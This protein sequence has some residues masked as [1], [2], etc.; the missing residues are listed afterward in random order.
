LSLA[1]LPTF[2]LP[3]T[4]FPKKLFFLKSPPKFPPIDSR[5]C[6]KKF[7]E[8]PEFLPK[9]FRF[10]KFFFYAKTWPFCPTGIEFFLPGIRPC[11]IGD[12]CRLFG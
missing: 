7:P 11:F 4:S 1:S 10:S 3:F 6:P 8:F 2:S 12:F 9:E 5:F